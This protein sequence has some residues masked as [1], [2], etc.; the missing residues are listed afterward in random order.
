MGRIPGLAL[1]QPAIMDGKVGEGMQQN[2][3][4][5]ELTRLIIMK[6]NFK[7]NCLFTRTFP[8]D[9][10]LVGKNWMISEFGAYLH[11]YAPQIFKQEPQM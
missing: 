7:R 9:N 6:D 5:I 4:V 1:R 3:A 2:I 10:G 8:L 11:Q